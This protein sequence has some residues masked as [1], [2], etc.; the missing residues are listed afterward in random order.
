MASRINGLPFTRTQL[1]THAYQEARKA[2]LDTDTANA[3]KDKV[4]E[5]V[6][7]GGESYDRVIAH[8]IAKHANA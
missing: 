6:L 4:L 5:R 8:E 1:A 7:L 3:I 2:G